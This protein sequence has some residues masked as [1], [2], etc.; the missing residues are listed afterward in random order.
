M[1]APQRKL[2]QRLKKWCCMAALWLGMQHEVFKT[3][4]LEI[5]IGMPSINIMLLS[6]WNIM[7]LDLP[8]QGH[9]ISVRQHPKSEY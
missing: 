8:Y 1:F 9:D 3:V 2:Y 7:S 6:G 4:E 5:G